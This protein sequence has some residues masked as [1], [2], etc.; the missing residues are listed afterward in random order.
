MNKGMRFAGL[1]TLISFVVISCAFCEAANNPMV[2][3]EDKIIANCTAT[4][5]A[6]PGDFVAYN[7]RGAAYM[8]KR[9][10][11]E[12]AADFTKAI[13]IN[14]NFATAYNSRGLI[15]QFRKKYDA[16]ID[17]YTHAVKIDAAFAQAYTNRAIVYNEKE[18]YDLAIADSTRSIELSPR[19]PGALAYYAKG[20]A[21]YMKHQYNEAL[22]AFRTLI[23]NS[24]N[25]AIVEKAKGYI[26]SMGGSV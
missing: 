16:A 11:D 9:L 12:A 17:D 8:A 26:R 4:I 14:P 22:E 6:N 15:N 1:F 24:N 20:Y 21:H 25:P 2:S 23:A 18:Q 13:E 3:P 19:M 5:A 10:F 7:S